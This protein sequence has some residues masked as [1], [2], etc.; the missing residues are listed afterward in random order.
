MYETLLIPSFLHCFFY[1]CLKPFSSLSGPRNA[2]NIASVNDPLNIVFTFSTIVCNVITAVKQAM[3][4]QQYCI[5]FHLLCIFLSF[6][7]PSLFTLPCPLPSFLNPLESCIC[8][9][10]ATFHYVFTTAGMVPRKPGDSV[11]FSPF[12]VGII[13]ALKQYHVETTHQFL[14]CL[15]QYVR[16]SV[17]SAARLEI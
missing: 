17:D 12:V 5:Y 11:D 4:Y 14:A 7:T 16:S 1:T 6:F 13:T 8:A 15:G 10:H 3:L 9:K 2:A